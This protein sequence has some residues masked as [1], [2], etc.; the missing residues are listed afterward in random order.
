MPK[1]KTPKKP[2]VAVTDY[3]NHYGA[4]GRHVA[5]SHFKIWDLPRVIAGLKKK[6]MDIRSKGKGG[7][8]TY[9]LPADSI[10]SKETVQTTGTNGEAA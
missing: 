9:F 1:F 6:G 2:E 4:I 3:L 5:A 8:L 10:E 7:D